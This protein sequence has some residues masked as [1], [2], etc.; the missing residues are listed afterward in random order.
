MHT[1]VNKMNR[2]ENDLLQFERF[3]TDMTPAEC[4]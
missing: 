4:C 1:Y 3:L 2:I